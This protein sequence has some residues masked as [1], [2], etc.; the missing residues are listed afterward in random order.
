M[1]STRKGARAGQVKQLEAP[2]ALQVT[3]ELSQ[4][5][6]VEPLAKKP[7]GH[8]ARHWLECRYGAMEGQLVHSLLVPPV[9][10]AQ[11]VSHGSQVLVLVL[12]YVPAAHVAE[13]SPATMY[14]VAEAHV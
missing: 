13:Q 6:H 10:V 12:A 3:H 9:Q 11:V 2:A 5:E 4:E 8:T 7:E 14:G 1:P